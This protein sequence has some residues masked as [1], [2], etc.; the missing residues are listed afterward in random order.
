MFSVCT[1]TVIYHNG[2]FVNHVKLYPLTGSIVMLIPG[3]GMLIGVVV[4]FFFPLRDARLA[5]LKQK[6]MEMHA[7]KEDRLA[8]IEAGR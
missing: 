8:Q 4:L 7:D 2:L 6:I 3:L 1:E 5:E